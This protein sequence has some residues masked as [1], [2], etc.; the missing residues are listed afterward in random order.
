[1]SWCHP[2][3]GASFSL[4]PIMPAGEILADVGVGVVDHILLY[5]RLASP[6]YELDVIHA[7]GV[8]VMQ[9]T[10]RHPIQ[11]LVAFERFHEFEMLDS[12]L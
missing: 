1:M 9:H 5:L 2:T 11:E 6:T 8:H 3:V 4:C 12:V 7:R 10:L